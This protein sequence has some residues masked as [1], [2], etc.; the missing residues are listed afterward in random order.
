MA[1]YEESNFLNLVNSKLIKYF[2]K[3]LPLGSLLVTNFIV[4]F[5][6]S[7]FF[8]FKVSMYIFWILYLIGF[9]FSL[10]VM[11]TNYLL[12]WKSNKQKTDKK[13]DSNKKIIKTPK[14]G[15]FNSIILLI[16]NVFF[17]ILNDLF[18]LT[19]IWTSLISLIY[20]FNLLTL[21]QNFNF[22][23]F[24][25]TIGLI[26]VLSGFFQFYI[27]NYKEQVSMKIANSITKY[28][29]NVVKKVS[30]NDFLN[31]INDEDKQE[32]KKLL[33][34]KIELRTKTPGFRPS[35]ITLVSMPFIIKDTSVFDNIDYLVKEEQIKN[36]KIKWE[37]L[38][39]FYKEYFKKKFNEFKKEIDEK[40]LIETRKLLFSHLIFFDE[41]L[42]DLEKINLEFALEEDKEPEGFKE[43]Y[44]KFTYDCVYYMLDI[45]LNFKQEDSIKN[46]KAD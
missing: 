13:E 19:I 16:K 33:S 36:F 35:P 28:L 4:L 9:L 2:I 39:K 38:N 41:V 10:I 42:A 14:T 43:H 23:K 18:M 24:A 44:E 20:I 27:K 3:F 7:Y 26:G 17:N 25:T 22:T 5:I 12:F 30:L 11:R 45:L 40:D 37:Q 32:L 8:D 15:F 29:I 21:P 6:F 31:N 34:D 46:Q 1:N